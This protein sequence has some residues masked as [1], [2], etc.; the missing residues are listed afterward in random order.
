MIDIA[1]I[2]AKFKKEPERIGI[3]S[4][5]GGLKAV[6]LER[7]SEQSL[8]V[9]ARGYIDVDLVKATPL[10]M[11]R[12][13]AMIQ[14]VSGG[15]KNAAIAIEHPTLRIRQMRIAPMP[16]RDMLEAIRWNFRE[17]VEVPMEQYSVGYTPIERFGEGEQRLIMAYGIAREAIEQYSSFV[18]T[19]GCKIVSVEP[20]ATAVLAAFDANKSWNE[21]QY[22]AALVIDA[23]QA[24]FLV[25]AHGT[26]LFSRLLTGVSLETL[27]KLLMRNM[28]IEEGPARQ[29]V[30]NW[31]GGGEGGETIGE[32]DL[33]KRQRLTMT[34]GHFFSQLVIEV[35]RTIDAFCIMYEAEKVDVIHVCGEGARFPGIIAHME[36]TLGVKTELFNPFERVRMR[37]EAV[38]ADAVYTTA[39]G[40]A[41]P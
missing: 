24:Y 38:S 40:L 1:D 6:R 21:G 25:M 37:E 10:E 28:V 9:V 5:G 39:V 34:I 4:C 7:A 18:K 30:E 11:Q 16:D 14:Q 36:K 33:D 29:E 20:V 3:D 35:Q 12:A 17:H 15:L 8:A 2:V 32:V 31:I 41:I 23:H 13:K 26:L 27:T 22:S 19:I